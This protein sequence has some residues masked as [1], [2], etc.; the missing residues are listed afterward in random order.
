MKQGNIVR[1]KLDGGNLIGPYL[2]VRECKEGVCYVSNG[3]N[4]EKP[5]LMF[6][7]KKKNL[8]KIETISLR[9]KIQCVEDLKRNKSVYGD[10][11]AQIDKALLVEN[12]KVLIAH[13]TGKTVYFLNPG[14][15]RV[16]L[17]KNTAVG[18]KLM[19]AYRLQTDGILW[20]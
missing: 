14:I 1:K 15:T 4:P 16:A 9:L 12:P 7:I 6:R 18:Y 20:Q 10:I 19:P 3:P 11:S 5:T 13:C 17:R 2:Y 8:V